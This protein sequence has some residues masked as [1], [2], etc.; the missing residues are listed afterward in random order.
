M[1]SSLLLPQPTLWQSEIMNPSSHKSHWCEVQQRKAMN[2]WMNEEGRMKCV[3]PSACR[4]VYSQ[5]YN[6]MMWQGC[7]PTLYTLSSICVNLT[8]R[9][10]CLRQSFTWTK[11]Y[12]QVLSLCKSDLKRCLSSVAHLCLNSV[13]MKTTFILKFLCLFLENENENFT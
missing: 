6:L 5:D 1:W 2:E 3:N 8:K 4:F 13:N 12:T 11:F 10:S 7:S 9:C